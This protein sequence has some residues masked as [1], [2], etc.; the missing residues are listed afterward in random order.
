MSH[1][2][3]LGVECREELL[4]RFNY[5]KSCQTGPYEIQYDEVSGAHKCPRC[6]HDMEPDYEVEGWKNSLLDIV[7]WADVI[8]IQRYT[9]KSHLKLI[10]EIKKLGKPVIGENDDNYIDIP[11]WNSGYEYYS[12]RLNVIEA[13]LKAFDHLCVTTKTLKDFYSA[14][15]PNITVIRNAL[16]L[17]LIDV[18]PKVDFF[19]VYNTS[20]KLLSKEE[21][22]NTRN[23][24]KLVCWAGSP[25]HEK[26]LEMIA[27]DM[28]KLAN[29][30]P[31]IVFGFVGY[32]CRMM[33]DMI[34][35]D[36]IFLYGLVPVSNYYSL[37]KS[38][39][40]QVALAPVVENAFN[41]GKSN[42]KVIEAQ[43]M[44]VFP[45]AS[46]SV[47]YRSAIHR[48]LLAENHGNSDWYFK[49][50]RA[51]SMDEERDL[52]IKENRI[53]VEREYNVKDTA[54]EWVSMFKKVLEAK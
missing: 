43:A 28:K 7:S 17:E 41:N 22:L 3:K 13:C 50:R 23:G 8:I 31:D 54:H 14:Y 39:D 32:V 40:I 44:N 52:A 34:P 48:G 53:F 11:K 29:K 24:R 25:T 9:H 18:S 30:E 35:K 10:E 15:N 16:D 49:T 45:V 42:L 2:A 5:C 33:L 36:R 12:S 20:G 46:N 6:G 38:L 47:T 51:I 27:Q 1:I 19:E 26:D 37:Y 4:E 21:Y